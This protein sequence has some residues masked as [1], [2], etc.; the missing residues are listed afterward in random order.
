MELNQVYDIDCIQGMKQLEAESIDMIL[1]DLPYGIT[2][3][4]RW[5]TPIDM[6][7][8][9]QQYRRIIKEHGAIVLFGTGIFT[10]DM[11][12]AGRDLYRY[13]LIWQKTNATNFLNANRMPL[14]THEDIMV[15]YKKRHTTRKRPADTNRSTTTPS[16]ETTA[17]TTEERSEVSEAEETL[18]DT[19]LR[20]SGQNQTSNTWHCIQHRSRWI[21]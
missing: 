16:L 1:C 3:R 10:A 18:T 15:F 20:L 9:W 12:A 11:M 7:E 8:L 21:F 5:D 2:A 4:N 14:R 6:T 13:N 17:P 19:L